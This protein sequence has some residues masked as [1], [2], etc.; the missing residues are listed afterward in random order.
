MSTSCP[1][2][3]PPGGRV[4]CAE[5]QFAYCHRE[6]GNVVSG[7]IP[8]AN[9]SLQKPT[10]NTIISV[11]EDVLS[12]AGVDASRGP[13]FGY[14][15]ECRERTDGTATIGARVPAVSVA[16]FLVDAMQVGQFVAFMIE[17]AGPAPATRQPSALFFRFPAI[18]QSDPGVPIFTPDLVGA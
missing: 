3:H 11:V 15:A 5:D 2:P 14:F 7:C 4:E 12:I 18:W 16:D 9:S 10:R 1:C 13:R 8:I 6:G 17:D